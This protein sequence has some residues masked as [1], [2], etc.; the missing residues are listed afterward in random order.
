VG[1]T[2]IGYLPMLVRVIEFDYCGPFDF[3]PAEFMKWHN[4]G[5]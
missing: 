4:F 3:K 1:I 2:T 5:P